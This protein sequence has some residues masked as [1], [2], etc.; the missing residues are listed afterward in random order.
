MSEKDQ[1]G[2]HEESESGVEY[3]KRV[4]EVYAYYRDFLP[5]LSD[6]AFQYQ[7]EINAGREISVESF[8]ADFALGA[9][10]R[11]R[12]VTRWRVGEKLPATTDER[13]AAI[14][15]VLPRFVVVNKE[16]VGGM[17]VEPARRYKID[18]V[19]EDIMSEAA[20]R[21]PRTLDAY[22][23]H[24]GYA[25]D[26][27]KIPGLGKV[28]VILHQT[29]EVL[30]TIS[31]IYGKNFRVWNCRDSGVKYLDRYNEISR[32]SSIEIEPLNVKLGIYSDGSGDEQKDAKKFREDQDKSIVWLVDNVLNPIKKTLLKE[33]QIDLPPMEEPFPE[34]KVGPLFAFVKEE[35]IEK[36]E[37]L[38]HGVSRAYPDE[39]TAVGPSKR[40]IP[41]N[42]NRGN[43]P[44]EVHD[45]FIWCGIGKVDKRMDTKN[46]RI[47]HNERDTW[48]M[49]NKEG[50]AEIKPL[51]ATDIY[52]VDWQAWDNYRSKTF[53]PGHDTLT[54]NEV[55]E[56]YRA[57]GK[58][59]VPISRYNGRYK[60]PVVLIGRDLEVNEIGITFIPPKDRTR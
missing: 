28:E 12:N 8:L 34:G 11:R 7:K 59:F 22:K 31:E 1:G 60:K 29:N 37:I 53:K 40:L 55:G 23:Y 15:S 32:P 35:D 3:L 33:K 38:K 25:K 9:E 20:Q 54:D 41:L 50:I 5:G 18:M 30:Y 49:F 21:L 48:G 58:T 51:T 27:V 16:A 42:Y 26:S 45:F 19:V 13:L 47:A 43:L 14:K 52:V 17:R 6:Q 2:P 24:Q 44:E 56:M 4:G 36:I 46:L 57:V 39:R 10:Q